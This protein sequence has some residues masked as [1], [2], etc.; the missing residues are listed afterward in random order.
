MH[1]LHAAHTAHAVA[2]LV[3]VVIDGVAEGDA[4]LPQLRQPFVVDLDTVGS[5][6]RGV[7]PENIAHVVEQPGGGQQDGRR[8]LFAALHAFH[9][10]FR[11]GVAVLL[12]HGK[13]VLRGFLILWN[14]L[15]H[16]V[17]L[18]RA[19]LQELRA[20]LCAGR[21]HHGRGVLCV[22]RES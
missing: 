13:P 21:A 9:E 12:R 18:H 22:E 6:G 11:V 3:L 7:V 20:L 1:L 14:T 2:L 5:G 4:L 17:Q 16:E 19:A 8:L 15:S 10:K